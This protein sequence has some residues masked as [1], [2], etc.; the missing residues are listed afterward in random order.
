MESG[1]QGVK[2]FISMTKR[3]GGKY[4]GHRGNHVA[5]EQRGD[6]DKEVTGKQSAS[7]CVCSDLQAESLK[8]KQAGIKTGVC[9]KGW[10]LQT[11]NIIDV[12]TNAQ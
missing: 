9:M 3:R 8:C 1:C 7:L 11:P 6:R 10:G 4:R 2:G 12:F 5:S